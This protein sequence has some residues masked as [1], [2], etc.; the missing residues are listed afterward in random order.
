MKVFAVQKSQ[1][2][3]GVF[4]LDDLGSKLVRQHIGHFYYHR[5]HDACEW[6]MVCNPR[7]YLDGVQW[8]EANGWDV[9]PHMQ[10]IGTTITPEQH[11]LLIKHGPNVALT[12][13][14]IQAMKKVSAATGLKTFHP[15]Q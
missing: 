4:S 5:L 12:D 6:L 10:D 3:A 7:D 8:L 15:F 2:I 11:A 14:T 9:L 1:T 13:N